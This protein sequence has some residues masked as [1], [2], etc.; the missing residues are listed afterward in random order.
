[1]G[2]VRIS[3]DFYDHEKFYGVTAL[4]I[5]TWI[6]GLAHANR[7]LTDGYISK[8]A[9]RGLVSFDRIDID[10]TPGSGMAGAGR[11][12]D[13]DDGIDELL[14]AGIWHEEGHECQACPAVSHLEYYM[15]D[16]LQFQPSKAE[17]ERRARE[18]AESGKKG[19]DR[20]WGKSE[21]PMADPMATPIASA[22]GEPIAKPW[23]NDAPNPNPNPTDGEDVLSS[24]VLNRE[25]T[26]L[27][28]E[29]SLEAVCARQAR[30]VYGVDFVKV[31][32]KVGALCDRFP[33]PSMV[34]RII[35]EIMGR[36]R[37]N[38]KDGTGYVLRS[39][40]NDWAEWQKFM[41]EEGAA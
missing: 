35:A 16:Y 22:M 31:R 28:G 9:A 34:M 36:S 17:V 15:H 8:R 40:A 32:N 3:D 6:A 41:D 5:A 26:K 18:R 23:L 14:T 12:A 19:A 29:E 4:G 11:S 27:D 39:I 10:L 24:P 33:D 30:D 25:G 37:Q 2:W 38:V 7:N 1:M 21:R 13:P 20:R